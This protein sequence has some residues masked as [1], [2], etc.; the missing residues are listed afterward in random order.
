MELL[1]ISPQPTRPW[2]KSILKA[3]DFT[4]DWENYVTIK[5]KSVRA[6][7]L[8]GLHDFSQGVRWWVGACSRTCR[9]AWSRTRWPWRGGAVDRLLA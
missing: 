7:A 6:V 3:Q 1:M 2:G 5:V 9:P 8:S 4:H